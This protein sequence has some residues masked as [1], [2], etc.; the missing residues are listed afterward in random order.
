MKV[1]VKRRIFIVIIIAISVVGMMSL[2]M[3]RP[4]PKKKPKQLTTM[5]VEVIDL[6]TSEVTFEIQSQGTVKPRTQTVLSA[7]VSGRIVSISDKFIAGGIFKKN[8]VLMQIDPTN[9]Q[10]AVD[11]ADALLKQREIEFNGAKSLRSKGYRAEAELAA[12]K[13]A[14]SAAKA[15]LVKANKNL[16]RTHIR[17]PYDGLVK[18]KNSDIGQFVNT[19]SHLGTTFAINSAEIRLALTD[20]E[21]AFL[22]LPEAG[23][24]VE[25]GSSTG[26]KVKLS[27]VRKGQHQTWDAHIVRTEGVVDEKSR[28]TYAVA[29]IDDPY[30]LSLTSADRINE[31]ALPIGTFVKATISGKSFSNIIKV[32]RSSIRG[33]NQLMFVD[34]DSRL[35]IKTVDILRAD[36]KF[37]YI[38]DGVFSGEKITITAI[39]SPIDGMKVRTGDEVSTDEQ[40]ANSDED[41]T[42]SNTAEDKS[43]EIKS[44]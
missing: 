7:E 36:S 25:K 20:Q 17:L 33:K 15:A 30:R 14:L 1:K 29:K 32:P 18:S 12:A 23:D 31:N 43:S 2:K 40:L 13:S 6:T 9:Y 37:A 41:A 26:P 21:L 24:I 8:E 34:E 42:N 16:D 10:V 3:M 4:E 38:R 44:N 5:L 22:D 11:Q 28:V 35:R 39:E 19:G 27:A